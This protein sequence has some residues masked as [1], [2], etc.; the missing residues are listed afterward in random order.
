MFGVKMYVIDLINRYIMEIHTS[1]LNNF[2]NT[3]SGIYY[4]ESGLE[5]RGVACNM[6]THKMEIEAPER[7]RRRK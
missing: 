3:Y 7:G 4:S 5:L 2:K 1:N 6:N